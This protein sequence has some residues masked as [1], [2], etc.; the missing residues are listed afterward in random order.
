MRVNEGNERDKSLITLKHVSRVD[1]TLITFAS[2]INT[3]ASILTP[4]IWSAC[5]ASSK[6][7]LSPFST[8]AST[9]HPP[10]IELFALKYLVSV[11]DC[12]LKYR[13][14]MKP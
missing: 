13:S 14:L 7:T 4:S 11:L 12:A 10:S 9:K 1:L 3:L 6:L 8:K 5:Q 2:F